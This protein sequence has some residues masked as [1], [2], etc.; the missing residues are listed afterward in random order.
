MIVDV[1]TEEWRKPDGQIAAVQIE[2]H[3]DGQEI[4]P[5][6]RGLMAQMLTDLGFERITTEPCQGCREGVP[7]YL[8]ACTCEVVNPPASDGAS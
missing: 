6:E 3:H 1:R 5:I 4:V 8:A 2:V 7:D